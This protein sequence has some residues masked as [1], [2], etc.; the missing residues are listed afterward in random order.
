MCDKATLVGLCMQDYKSRCAA[1]T[2][3]ATI[4][5]TKLD[6]YIVSPATSKLCQTAGGALSYCTREMRCKFG[7]S[8]LQRYFLQ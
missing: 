2:I 1:A 7:D 4:F 3:C 6:F 5:D 8:N